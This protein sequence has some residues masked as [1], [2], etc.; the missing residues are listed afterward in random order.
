MNNINSYELLPLSGS[1]G[2]TYLLLF[3][4]WP[5]LAFITALTNYS[6]RDAKKVVY[7]FLIYYGLTFVINTEGYVDAVGYTLTFTGEESELPFNCTED[8]IDD[9]A[10]TAASL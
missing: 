9:L 6:Q 8:A 7:F 4:V 1:S 3:I 2:K 5:F 10:I